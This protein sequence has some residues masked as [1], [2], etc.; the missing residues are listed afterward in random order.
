MFFDAKQRGLPTLDG[1]AFRAFALF[2]PGRKLAFVWILLMAVDAIGEWQ[3]F[4]EVAIQMALSARNGRVL[5]QQGVF[6]FRMVEFEFRQE[7]F[8]ACGCVAILAT[9][10]ERPLVG[11]D[12]A[13][14]AS[15]KLHVFV[16]RGT[17]GPIGFVAL[18]AGHLHVLTGQGIA[19]LPMI[20]LFLGRFPVEEIEILA[21]VLEV[22]PNAIFP[23]RIAHLYLVVVSVLGR[24]TACNF[25]VAFQTFER[26]R[27]GSE[28]MA[29][30]ALGGAAER[31]MGLRQWT[32]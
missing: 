4:L 25:L 32:G 13:V 14:D 17:A 6:G 5:A 16:A 31:F 27:A 7:F 20:K 18:F 30:R 15:R 23:V 12:V 28:L 8:P 24:E 26:R 1:V 19:G 11:I 9:L 2:G 22:T 29:A 10:L 3:R 21:V